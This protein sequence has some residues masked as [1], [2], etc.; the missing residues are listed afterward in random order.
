MLKQR[1]KII[2]DE[3]RQVGFLEAAATIDKYY[4]GLGPQTALVKSQG[5]IDG[6]IKAHAL[7]DDDANRLYAYAGQVYTQKTKEW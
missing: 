7:H 6:L 4:H 3:Q 2:E 1:R 5:F